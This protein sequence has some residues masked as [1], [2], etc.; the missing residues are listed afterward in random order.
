M[1]GLSPTLHSLIRL[2][3]VEQ[4]PEYGMPCVSF[5]LPNLPL[6]C[7]DGISE[8]FQKVVLVSGVF[9]DGRS[10]GEVHHQLPP[11]LGTPESAAA[12]L[13]FALGRDIDDRQQL[14]DWV[15]LGRANQSLVPLVADRMAYQN[16]PHCQ[17]EADFARV[18]RTRLISLIADVSDGTAFLISFDGSLLRFSIAQDSVEVPANGTAWTGSIVVPD[19]ARLEFPKRISADGITLEY[20]QESVRIG[21]QGHD[22][23]WIEGADHG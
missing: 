15:A 23:K 2:G 8:H 22:A 9:N 13:V 14:P 6:T 19:A 16:R 4:E 3:F 18:L 10:I 5:D 21:N 1:R 11:D 12:W 17:I 20:W 7:C